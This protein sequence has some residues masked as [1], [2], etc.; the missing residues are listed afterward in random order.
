MLEIWWRFD[1][2][3][4]LKNEH[5]DYIEGLEYEVT[6]R[7]RLLDFIRLNGLDCAEIYEKELLEYGFMF[8]VAISL[9][10]ELYLPE[11]EAKRL[12]TEAC[13]CFDSKTG[14]LKIRSVGH[15]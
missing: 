15:D 3:I 1:M 8:Q 2:E 10:P 14:T 6:A 9:L 11:D 7:R 5:T 12:G 13:R 4:K